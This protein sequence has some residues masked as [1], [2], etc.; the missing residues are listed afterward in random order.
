MLQPLRARHPGF[1][2]AG[3]RGVITPLTIPLVV[4]GEQS[5]S[6]PVGVVEAVGCLLGGGKKED[7]KEKNW[8]GG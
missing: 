4:W 2:D 8:A 6:R 3:N 5:H 7:R 1:L